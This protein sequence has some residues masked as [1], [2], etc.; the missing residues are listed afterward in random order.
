MPDQLVEDNDGADSD[1]VDDDDDEKGV[2]SKSSTNE[3]ATPPQLPASPATYFVADSFNIHRLII[4]GVT[5]A[6]KFFSD[7]F[8]TN[9]RY[10]KVCY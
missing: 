9:S 1:L 10:A 3:T 2:D 5:C 4:A 6:S 7:V 8:Y